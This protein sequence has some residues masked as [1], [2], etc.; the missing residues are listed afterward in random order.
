M[1]P[2]YLDHN[3]TTPLGPEARTA[4]EPYLSGQFGNPLT[5]HR[6]GE[7]PRAA[8]EA[9]RAE[10]LALAGVRDA[11]FDVIFGSGGTE[12]L[13]H[14]VKG[15]AFRSLDAGRPGPRRR[16]VIGA[17]EHYAVAASAK[18][19]AER[20]GFDVA[21]VPPGRDGVVPVEGFVEAIE[22]GSTLLAALQ[23]ANNE[24]GTLQPVREVGRICRD[25]GV[26]F[27]VDAVQCPG[28]V[29]LDD[30]PSFADALAFSAHKLYGPKGAGA[31]V[32]RRDLALDPLVHGARQEE[33]RR[34]GTHH[35][36]GIVGFGAAA[37]AARE[38]A[39]QEAPRLAS[40]RDQLWEL[41]ARRIE[42]VHWNGRGAPLL[43]NTL[44]VSFEGC[45]SQLLCEEMDRRFVAVSP[46]AACRSGATTPSHTLQAMGAGDARATS[47]VRISL[48]HTTTAH[49]VQSTADALFES[50]RKV[51]GSQ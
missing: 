2:I 25:L 34:G 6:F 4:M 44:N 20:F 43:P 23:W 22:R 24:V 30:A 10:V 50:V 51:R 49:D 40:L 7:S 36:A 5:S 11:T 26:P 46:G 48:G 18:W 19:L 12:A 38:G 29:A 21:L 1:R 8:V 14:A 3:A 33:G 35:V 9:A 31:L 32:V 37:R 39:A 28:K 45:P 41:I 27:V 15:I 47:S 17:L 13:N 42:R 16:I